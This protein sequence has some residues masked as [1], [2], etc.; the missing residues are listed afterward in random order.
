MTNPFTAKRY[1]KALREKEFPLFEEM[2]KRIRDKR[3]IIV[4]VRGKEGSGMSYAAI[5]IM[6]RITK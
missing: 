5:N 6:E 3:R 2:L 4:H 1:E